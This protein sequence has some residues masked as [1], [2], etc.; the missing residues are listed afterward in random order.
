MH[1]D[2]CHMFKQ[3]LVRCFHNVYY[4]YNELCHVTL[5]KTLISKGTGGEPHLSTYIQ[6]LFNAC[7]YASMYSYVVIDYKNIYCV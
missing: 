3:L 5:A 7:V 1:V 6:K 4:H 2:I